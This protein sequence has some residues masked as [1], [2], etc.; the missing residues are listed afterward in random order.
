MELNANQKVRPMPNAPPL[1]ELAPSES[2]R[3]L[4]VGTNRREAN[5]SANI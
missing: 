4:R 3:D 5:E 2:V 1:S